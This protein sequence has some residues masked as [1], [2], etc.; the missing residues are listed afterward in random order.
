MVVENQYPT[1]SETPS[2]FGC[3]YAALWHMDMP[4]LAV[5]P[6]AAMLLARDL[7]STGGA[8]QFSDLGAAWRTLSSGLQRRIGKMTVVHD[9][10]TIRRRMGLTDPA[11][12]RSDLPATEH[13]LVCFDPF[14]GKKSLLFSAHTSHV[15]DLP[16]EEGNALLEDLLRHA[17]REDLVYSHQWR[18]FDLVFW[19]NRRT[20]HRVLPYN[21][22]SERRRLWRVE[23]LGT[24]QPSNR[25]RSIWRILAPVL[26]AFGRASHSPR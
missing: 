13:P 11:E 14:S 6:L 26:R 15:K 1:R 8:T 25:P 24:D 9:L 17:T 5:P 16:D 2:P 22:G 10:Q 4:V 21:D 23:V 12:I 7:P 18:R 3:G 20:L 19:N